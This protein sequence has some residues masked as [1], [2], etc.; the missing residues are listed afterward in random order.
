MAPE[1][2]ML[3]DWTKQ[4][5][6]HSTQGRSFQAEKQKGP[7]EGVGYAEGAQLVCLKNGKKARVTGE[8]F[9]FERIPVS[10]ARELTYW[11]KREGEQ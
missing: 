1:E 9:P 7:E 6:T 3:Q 10:P 4:G 5:E 2:V 11:N 8:G